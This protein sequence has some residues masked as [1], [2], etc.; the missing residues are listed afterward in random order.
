MAQEQV[1]NNEGIGEVVLWLTGGTSDKLHWIS[2]IKTACSAAT[3]SGYASY[4]QSSESGLTIVSAATVS[5]SSDSFTNDTWCVAH[6]FTAGATATVKGFMVAN[7]SSD[8]LYG[9]CCYA[10]DVNMASSDTLT[11]TMKG[12]LK[13]G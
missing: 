7:S 4:T 11:N 10:A 5:A 13:N 6:P 1:A 2:C 12:R 3:A 8:A 9:V